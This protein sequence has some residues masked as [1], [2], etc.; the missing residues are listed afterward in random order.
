LLKHDRQQVSVAEEGEAAV[1][2]EGQIGLCYVAAGCRE[3]P[4]KLYV[5]PNA[6]L[7]MV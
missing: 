1:G 4:R 3:A 6:L 7:F 5:P 2:L